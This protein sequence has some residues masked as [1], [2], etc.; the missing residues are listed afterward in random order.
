MVLCLA[1]AACTTLSGCIRRPATLAS[2]C[3]RCLELLDNDP[4]Y[5]LIGWLTG[6][7]TFLCSG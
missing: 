6:A 4:K 5:V 7:P 3:C 2:P 1:C